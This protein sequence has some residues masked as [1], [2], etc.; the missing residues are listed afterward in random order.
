MSRKFY[1]NRRFLKQNRRRQALTES[2]RF[3]SKI[4]EIAASLKT[5]EEQAK[6]ALSK[7]G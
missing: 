7:V 6:A 2:A 5:N 1:E 3:V 4:K